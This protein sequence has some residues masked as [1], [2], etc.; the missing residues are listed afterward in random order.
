MNSYPKLISRG[1]KYIVQARYNWALRLE[2]LIE[3]WSTLP[4][5]SPRKERINVLKTELY[6]RLKTIAQMAENNNI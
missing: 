4:R 6:L 2:R 1:S 5:S 3:A